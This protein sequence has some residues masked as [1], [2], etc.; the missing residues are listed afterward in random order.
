[1]ALLAQLPVGSRL[2]TKHNNGLSHFL[3][4]MLFTGTERWSEAEVTDV[5]RRRGGECNAQTS[6]ESTVYHLHLAAHDIAFGMD[7]LHQ[8]LFRPTLSPEKFEKERQVIINEKGGE[9][10]RLQSAWEW[11][12]DRNL[13]WHVGRAVR[14][15]LYPDSSLLLPIIG[16]DKT[17]KALTHPQLLD[18]YRQHY[19]PNNV[20]LL[21]VGDIEPEHAF[22]LA[23]GQFGHLPPRPLPAGYPPTRVV[24][25]P[26]SV[27]ILGPTPNEQ[28]QFLIGAL[29]ERAD[30]PDRFAWWT[31]EEM[32]E[33]AYLR[34]IRFHLGLSYDVNVF[35]VLY[36]DTGYFC[37]YTT[38]KVEDFAVIRRLVQKHLNRLVNGEFSAEELAEAQTAL[39]GRA[40]LNLQDNLELAWWLTGD[41]L[42]AANDETPIPDYF[43]EIARLTPSDIQRV[44]QRYL[45]PERRFS[46]EHRPALT[47][48][49]LKPVAGAGAVGLASA[50]V[51]F[52]LR[53]RHRRR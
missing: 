50:A 23:A 47:P 38:A 33:N 13:G 52:A 11:V 27:R 36:T 44:A 25:Q 53:P 22:A 3:E 9:F 30:H 14:R 43:A 6:R 2:E 28:G 7:W 16:R 17:L 32:L 48:G 18:Y 5:V 46:V 45:A 15:R 39:R 34:D 29:L 8:L 20:T 19:T 4:H 42:I 10:D 37:I 24:E 1:V 35:T 21:V 51:L 12:E 40:L 49:R 31:I 26:F 41:A